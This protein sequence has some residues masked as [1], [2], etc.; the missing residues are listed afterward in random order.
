MKY[1]LALVMLIASP[2]WAGWEHVVQD[3]DG[4]RFLIDYQTIRKDGNKVKF[5]QL[6]NYQ[7][8]GT[9]GEVK[10]VSTRSRQEYDCKQEQKRVLTFAAFDTWNA[11]GKA[12]FTLEET[13]NWTEIPPETIVWEIMKKVCKAPAR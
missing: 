3:E 5:W 7:K 4:A 1:L 2:A 13:G 12:V 11:N 8:P 10:Y 6:V 9:F